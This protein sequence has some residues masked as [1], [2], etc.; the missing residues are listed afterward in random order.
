MV[1]LFEDINVHTN[2]QT[3]MSEATD[4]SNALSTSLSHDTTLVVV[5]TEKWWVQSRASRSKIAAGGPM[6]SVP[7]RAVRGESRRRHGERRL[8]RGPTDEHGEPDALRH[9]WRLVLDRSEFVP[10]AR[11][12]PVMKVLLL[13]QR[14]RRAA[15][16]S[17]TEEQG[18]RT[19]RHWCALKE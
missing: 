17:Q 7:C 10:T 16:G 9:Y 4:P 12:S 2:F 6:Q 13:L 15:G 19:P 3:L 18:T 8:T 14:R 5:A 11:Q 1:Y